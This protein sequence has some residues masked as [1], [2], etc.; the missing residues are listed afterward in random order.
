MPIM[1]NKTIGTGVRHNGGRPGLISSPHQRLAHLQAKA[2]RACR[3][4]C[5]PLVRIK[6]CCVSAQ[7]KGNRWNSKCPKR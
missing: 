1:A 6:V 3:R 4:P 2:I 7:Q 5:K